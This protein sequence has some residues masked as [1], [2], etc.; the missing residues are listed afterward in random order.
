MFT[1]FMQ[2][3]LKPRMSPT[4]NMKMPQSFLYSWLGKFYDDRKIG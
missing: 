2:T 3:E 1:S 4:I